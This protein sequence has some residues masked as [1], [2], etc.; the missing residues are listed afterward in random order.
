MDEEDLR[1]ARLLQIELAALT[2]IDQLTSLQQVE[3]CPPLLGGNT[4][5]M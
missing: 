3:L 2:S 4:M 1:E 5:K